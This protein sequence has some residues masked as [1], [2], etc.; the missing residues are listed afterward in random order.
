[1]AYAPYLPCGGIV[2]IAE[3]Q[4]L[5][6]RRADLSV[7]RFDHREPKIARGVV[8]AVE[9]ARDFSIG[10]G[11]HHAAGMRELLGG[12]VIAVAEPTRVGERA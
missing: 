5:V 12:R 4:Q 3:Q 10:R 6:D 1:M 11:N 7:R 8:H 9:V 2:V